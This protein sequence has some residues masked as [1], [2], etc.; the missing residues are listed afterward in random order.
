MGAT[1]CSHIYVNRLDQTILDS[2]RP[3]RSVLPSSGCKSRMDTEQ[4]S[5]GRTL[6]ITVLD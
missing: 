1:C 5:A 2:V 6:I 4:L 3:E